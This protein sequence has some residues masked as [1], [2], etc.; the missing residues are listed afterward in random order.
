[1]SIPENGRTVFWAWYK[2]NWH[3]LFFCEEAVVWTEPCSVLRVS[4]RVI[5]KSA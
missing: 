5:R 3:A 4:A 1:M 2:I